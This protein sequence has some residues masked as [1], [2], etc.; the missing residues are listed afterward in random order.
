MENS[1]LITKALS[2]IRHGYGQ[3]EMTIEDV[4]AHAGFSTNYFNR[5]FFAHTGF[6][7]MEYVRFTRLKSAARLLRT[8]DKDILDIAF[9]C[10]YESQESFTRAFKKQYGMPPGEYRKEHE[11]IEAYYGDFYNDTVGARLVHEFTD[12][13]IADTDEVIDYLLEKDPLRYGYTAVCFRVNGGAALYKGEDFRDGF[14]WFS[15]WDWRDRPY[16]GE[17]VSGDYERIADYLRTFDDERFTMVIDSPDPLETVTARLAEYGAPVSREI[18]VR[19]SVNV[20]SGEPYAITPPAGVTVRELTHDDFPLIEGFYSRLHHDWS[21][22]RLAY[23]KR[24]L[25]ERDVLG[26]SE[27]SVFV[28]GVFKN[29]EM[30]GFSVGGLQR[31]HGFVVNNCVSTRLLPEHESE[32]TYRLVFKHV[33]NT[34]LEKGALPMDDIQTPYSDDEGKSGSF[35]STDM[36]YKTVLYTYQ[37]K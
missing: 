27:H 34:A 1:E 19:S 29:G 26:N 25:H 5:I 35:N 24:E 16:E 28:F 36:G 6:N 22:Q 30:I 8:T 18:S 12:Y 13:K 32:E 23:M 2:Y 7:V 20:Y 33:T 3:C 4:A 14:I 37:V 17:I 10:G 21:P 11:K 31:T 15:E 9:D